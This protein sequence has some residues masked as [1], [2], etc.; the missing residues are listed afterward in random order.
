MGYSVFP[1]VSSNGLIPE[2]WCLMAG[3]IIESLLS[4][5]QVLIPIIAFILGLICVMA[6]A[7]VIFCIRFGIAE[8]IDAFKSAWK[9]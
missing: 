4:A 7:F 5:I 3:I 1:F 8:A 9:L 6:V 2:V